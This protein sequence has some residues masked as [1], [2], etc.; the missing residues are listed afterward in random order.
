MEYIIC[1][2]ANVKKKGSR[3]LKIHMLAG[4]EIFAARE[5]F[6]FKAALLGRRSFVVYGHIG[7]VLKN[8]GSLVK[9]F[10][11]GKPGNF[12]L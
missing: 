8:I 2:I 9:G 6:S 5:T 7:L 1:H 4:E 10:A 12:F 3:S 11:L